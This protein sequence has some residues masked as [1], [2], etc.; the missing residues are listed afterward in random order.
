MGDAVR[1]VL[2]GIMVPSGICDGFIFRRPFGGPAIQRGSYCIPEY[3]YPIAAIFLHC[4]GSIRRR[5]KLRFLCEETGYGTLRTAVGEEDSTSTRT[6]S[7]VTPT[8]AH[9]TILQQDK[10]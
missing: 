2:Y 7:N 9:H 3:I 1:L 6:L 4:E 10:I 8:P 5:L